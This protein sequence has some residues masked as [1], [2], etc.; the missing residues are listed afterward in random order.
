MVLPKLNIRQ[1]IEG[2]PLTFNAEA[3]GDLTATIQFDV[4]GTEPGVYH[5]HIAKGECTFHTG[6]ADE[7]T[8]TIN[9]PS[10]VWL[11]VSRGEISGQDA[12]MQGLYTASGD[13][14]LMLKMNTL[15]KSADDADFEAPAG[16]RPAGPIP[17][18]GMAWMTVAFIPWIL[19]WIT[20]DIPGVGRWISVG[21]PLL[22][23]ALIVAYRLAFSR[24]NPQSPNTQAPTFLEW[25]GLGFFSLAGVLALTGSHGY[26]VWGSILSSVVMGGLWFSSLLFAKMPLSGEYSKWGFVKALWRN[27]M[28]LYPNAIISLMWGWQFIA[29]SFLGIAALLLPGQTL[30]FTLARYLLLVP[31]FIFTSVYQK[32]VPIPNPKLTNTEL[33]FWAGLGLSA[34]SGLLLTATMPGFDVGLLGWIALIPLLMVITTAP[35]KQQYALALPF[36][37]LLSIG[38]HNWYPHIF[39]PA[40]GYFLIHA[41]GTFYA[42]IIQLGV[43]IQS[44]VPGALKLLAIPVTW[45]AVEFVKFIAPVV[46]D[47]WFVL[48]AKSQWRFPPALQ[49]LSVTGFPGLSFLIVLANVAI[50][51]LVIRQLGIRDQSIPKQAS[52]T[53]LAV[54][55]GILLWGALTIP[56]PPSNTFTI[57]A[58]T[59]MVNQD[60][61]VL[62]TSEFAPEDFGTGANPPETSQAIFDVDAAL[63]RSV[64][65]QHPTFIVWPENEF[66]DADDHHFMSQLRGLAAEIGS[67]IVADV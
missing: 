17:L 48:L 15:F 22:L 47:W 34:V 23:S 8:L 37:L 1:T 19:H 42:G 10:D 7:P 67:Y 51:A 36:G 31:A 18:P 33:R 4:T 2:M 62:S 65:D 64:V 60:P 53:A 26:A 57:A 41:V 43:W 63:T 56:K 3:A 13:L 45:S 39:P 28:F 29:A 11:Q 24:P 40:L 49:I 55:A 61:A 25:G 44:R 66:A 27:S 9:T 5:L 32:R 20:F 21:L 16:Q 59:D 50:T 38:V 6:P 58:L 52:I 46:E 30:I 14:S 12:L 35:A 54:V